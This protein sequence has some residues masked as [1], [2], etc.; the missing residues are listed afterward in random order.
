[1]LSELLNHG[2]GDVPFIP[3]HFPLKIVQHGF[4]GGSIIDISRSHFDG[5]DFPLVIYNHVELEAEEPAHCTSSALCEPLE[6][7]V[8]VISCIVADG[9]LRTVDK[10]DA[11]LLAA[12]ALK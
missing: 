11:G 2:F 7:L 8:A 9:Q 4:Q 10:V 5:H 12:K 3:E 1:M 6:D